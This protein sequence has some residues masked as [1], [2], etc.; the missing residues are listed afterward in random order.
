MPNR[1]RQTT[2]TGR[3]PHP[4]HFSAGLSWP[5][6]GPKP[7]TPIFRASERIGDVRRAES[8]TSLVTGYAAPTG[9]PKQ[10]ASAFARGPS[11]P[12]T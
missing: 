1:E 11:I 6:Q 4:V 9:R 10:S 8:L 2:P 3:E 7:N 12:S 5:Y